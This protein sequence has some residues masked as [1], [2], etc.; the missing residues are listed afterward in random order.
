MKRV[1]T[2]L[3]GAAVVFSAF[4][5]WQGAHAAPAETGARAEPSP[6]DP[7]RFGDRQPD[8]A[9]G[10]FQRGLYITALNIA[11]PRAR[12]GD[13]AA[14]ILIAEIYARGLGV[15][16]DEKEAARWY[17]EAAGHGIPEAQFQYALMLIDGRFV[18]RDPD[19][20]YE[21]MEKAA[22]SGNPMAQFN[23][24]QMV[25]ERESGFWAQEKAVSYFQLAAESGLADAQYAMAE[26]YIEGVGGKPQS[27]AMAREML[28]RAARQNY[29]TAQLTLATWLVEGRGGPLDYDAGFLW[30]R[31][32]AESGNV[33]AQN[34][35]AKLYWY[36]L[37]TDGDSIRAGAWYIKA[38]RAGLIDPDMEGFLDGLTNEERT[39]AIR[40]ANRL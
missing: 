33:A 23:Y 39:E 30:M 4:A 21:L 19:R 24:A 8:R 15:P 29:D 36:G 31:R 25:L 9:F 22:D 17:A 7:D 34:R 13:P 37:G 35:L 32:A 3:L 14:Q 10:A 20:A 18:E 5:G 12:D 1:V 27:D 11:L 28:L 38:R 2:G 26:V 40:L 16:R 6:V